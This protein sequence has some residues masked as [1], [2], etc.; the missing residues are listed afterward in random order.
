MG[1]SGDAMGK[2]TLYGAW[3]TITP[4]NG[5]NYIRLPCFK[6]NK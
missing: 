4:E 1:R 6:I 3:I 5:Y 2:E